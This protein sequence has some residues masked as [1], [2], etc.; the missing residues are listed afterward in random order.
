MG[1]TVVA[2]GVE[3]AGQRDILLGLRCDELQG[4]LY[5]RPMP[6][7]Q[8]MRWCLEARSAAPVAIAATV[9]LGGAIGD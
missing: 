8:L 6:P 9:A 7:A 4:Y 3:T 2:E 5:A 1:L